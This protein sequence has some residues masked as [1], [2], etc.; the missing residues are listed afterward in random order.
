MKRNQETQGENKAIRN[1]IL[2]I[3]IPI[4]LENVFQVSANIV[5]TAMVGRLTSI[6]ISAQGICFSIFG[7]VMVLVKGISI[8]GA[9]YI[10]RFY[11]AKNYDDAKGMFQSGL[12]FTIGL[13]VILQAIIFIFSESFFRFMTDNESVI[14]LAQGYI[15]I[16]IVGM[17]F[18]VVMSFVTAAFQGFGDTKT[19]MFIAI[20]M[21]IINITLG[22]SLIFGVGSFK[23]LGIFGAVIALVVAQISAAILG[24]FL[25]CRP[26]GLFM[27]CGKKNIWP[28]NFKW[29]KNIY[30]MGIPVSVESVFW[31]LSAIV[32]SKI[33]LS[34]G[35]EYFAAYQLGIQAET[36]TELP[37]I[38]FG[39][40]AVTLTSRAIGEN[41]SQLF[42]SYIGH[43]IKLS[44]GISVV[45]SLLLLIFP[46]LFMR[47][48]TDDV[49]LQN[50]GVVY[51]FV[52]GF[53]QV[54]Q[55]LSRVFNGT[56]RSVGYK[57]IPMYIA[58]TGIWLFRIPLAIAIAY[59]VKGDIWLIWCCIAVD[60]LVR[61]ILSVFYYKKK[62]VIH[63]ID[64]L[65]KGR[66]YKPETENE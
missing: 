57:N 25:I 1:T 65:T 42:K 40:A 36:L 54:P 20:F 33:I 44:A 35:Q 47:L 7:V 38:G 46:R 41:N 15:K 21:N 4:I 61:F 62:K 53:I 59:I 24:L 32:M 2:L 13:V 6:D 10:S 17:P 22:Y 39:V 37:A 31:Q 49:V 48:F 52:M 14:E 43:L 12:L 30:A 55:N 28:I 56:I 60:Q 3:I 18:V 11:G 50:I 51:I 64:H 26:N 34:Y 9:L 19:P 5:S 66:I 45:T 63:Y 27:L 23:G 58:G 8:G 29:V 16:L